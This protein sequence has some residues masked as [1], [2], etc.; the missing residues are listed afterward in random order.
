MPQYLFSYGTLQ[1]S[2]APR[3]IASVVSALRRVGKGTVRGVLFDLGQYPG[4]VQQ[5]AGGAV[6]GTVFELPDDPTVLKKLDEYEGFDPCRPGES[7]F[8]R[9]PGFVQLANG[10]RKKCWLYIYNK[11]TSQ[12][13]LISNGQYRKRK[14]KAG[15][16]RHLASRG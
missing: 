6:K 15:M 7:L 11:P 4:I 2:L 9:K 10:Q 14:S 1:P 5:K 13:R 8:I 3:E 16:V 12:A